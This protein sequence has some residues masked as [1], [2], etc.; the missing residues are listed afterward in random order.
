MFDTGV[1]SGESAGTPPHPRRVLEPAFGTARDTDL[2]RL[3]LGEEVHG[4]LSDLRERHER[5][6]QTADSHQ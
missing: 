2:L 4:R 6:D 5:Q 3:V 1:R